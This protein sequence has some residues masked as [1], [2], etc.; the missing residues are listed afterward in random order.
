MVIHYTAAG[1]LF[2]LIL[3]P[4]SLQLVWKS[5]EYT[6]PDPKNQTLKVLT[7]NLHDGFNTDGRLD[8]E[9]LAKII[10]SS[11][12]DVVGLQ[13][14]SRGW[15]I[16][17]GVDMLTWLSQRLNMPYVSGPTA[18]PQWGNAILSRYPLK[19]IQLKQLPTDDLLIQRGFIQADIDVGSGK[20]NLIVTHFYHLDEKP[21]IRVLQSEEIIRNIQPDKPTI[22]VGDLNATPDAQE[23]RILENSGMVDLASVLGNPPTYTYYSAAPYEQIDYI[24]ISNGLKADHFNITNTTASDHF[25][26]FSNISMR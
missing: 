12:A 26:V 4:L 13:E 11:S 21:E 15:L 5:P 2:L 16:W 9:T 25:P 8:L 17:G 20:L 14:V 19:N 22:L 18:D 23:M 3:V 10:E 7:Y 1:I 6:Q 24:W